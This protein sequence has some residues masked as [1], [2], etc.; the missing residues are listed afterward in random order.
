MNQPC[1][2]CGLGTSWECFDCPRPA[3][4]VCTRVDCRREHERRAGCVAHPVEHEPWPPFG[5]VQL[6]Y[7]W[8][9]FDSSRLHPL[10]P[11]H[12]YARAPGRT[13]CGRGVGKEAYGWFSGGGEP[14]SA[15]CPFGP[16]CTVCVSLIAKRRTMIPLP[17]YRR[18]N[19]FR[20]EQEAWTS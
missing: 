14:G 4:Y 17:E 1:S 5:L 9:P 10:S 15:D 6:N 8:H 18:R 2:E 20:R 7:D 11:L 19:Q 13:L 16:V 3:P 12:V